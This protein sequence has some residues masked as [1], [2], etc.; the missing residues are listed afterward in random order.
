MKMKHVTLLTII[1]GLVAVMPVNAAENSMSFFVT[2][3]GSG[4][5]G[6]L[7]GVAGA[8]A[9]CL[10]LATA[11][12]AGGRPWHAYLSGELEGKRGV[13]ARDRIGTGP[14]Y[15]AKGVLILRVVVV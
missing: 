4:K 7:G 2:S 9:H 11:V 6:D 5:G 8:D 10:A 1:C 13:S 15:H 3:E 12:G 14:W